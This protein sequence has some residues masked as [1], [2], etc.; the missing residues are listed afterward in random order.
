MH[1][2]LAPEELRFS[3]L[4]DELHAPRAVS[5]FTDRIT[6]E[7]PFAGGVVSG[8]GR[9]RRDSIGA[10]F[11]AVVVAGAVTWG[12][13]NLHGAR[14]P[15]ASEAS[16]WT[17]LPTPHD[18]ALNSIACVSAGGCWAVGNGI[19]H[20]SGSRWTTVPSHVPAG[21]VLRGVA[22]VTESDCWAVGGVQSAYTARPLIEHL[23]G[24]G[25]TVASDPEL[26]PESNGQVTVFDAVTCV[27]STYCWAVGSSGQEGGSADQPLVANYSATGWHLA[28]SPR[29]AGPGSDLNAVGCVGPD[30]CWA[31]GNQGADPL[32]EHYA[33]GTWSV[34]ASPQ[35]TSL[36]GGG[37]NAVSCVS[38]MECWAVGYTGAGVT[39]QPLIEA[40]ANGRWT[41][42]LSP[43]ITS[44]NGG[45]LDGVACPSPQICWAVGDYSGTAIAEPVQS[46]SP[47]PGT[48]VATSPLIERSSPA[49]WAVALGP[50]STASSPL[51][52]VSCSK[53]TQCWSVGGSIIATTS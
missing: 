51:G 45:Q 6:D 46:P 4:L 33:S 35:M 38:A 49:G 29:L 21:G 17:V 41:S 40:Y 3:E 13:F 18:L 22:C 5:H 32:V 44:P 31:V 30:D 26:A 23:V 12:Y 47:T 39:E 43:R 27:G 8:R 52:S 48:M 24:A 42:V 9:V 10:V 50:S 7:Y 19:E 53:A 36:G 20:Y 15:Q 14:S 16:A 11:V 37:L 34:F 1:D 25:W 2:D 28:A